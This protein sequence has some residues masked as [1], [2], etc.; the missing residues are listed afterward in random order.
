M[1]FSVGDFSKTNRF[2]EMAFFP[3]IPSNNQWVSFI[4]KCDYFCMAQ[5]TLYSRLCQ[6]DNGSLL[7]PSPFPI[8]SMVCRYHEVL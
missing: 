3:L 7:L 6:P 8:G 4:F 1:Q 2:K 5:S